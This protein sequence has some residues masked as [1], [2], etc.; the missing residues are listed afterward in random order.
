MVLPKDSYNNPEIVIP[1][2][3]GFLLGEDNAN[4]LVLVTQ[5]LMGFLVC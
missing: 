1:E 5:G 2:L 4:S 3:Q